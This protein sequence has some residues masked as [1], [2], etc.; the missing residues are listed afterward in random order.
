MD[1]VAADPDEA[2]ADAPPDWS[3]GGEEVQLKCPLCGY[4][5]RGLVDPRCPECGYQ[6]QWRALLD[7]ARH[8]HPFLFEHHPGHNIRSFFPTLRAT[9]RP[10]RFWR[11]LR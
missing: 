2:L 11:E 9:L 5:L 3:A 10:R 1:V 7:D 6:F 4:N 8:R